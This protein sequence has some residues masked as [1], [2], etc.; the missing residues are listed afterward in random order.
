MKMGKNNKDIE[1]IKK[2]IEKINFEI[3][4][5]KKSISIKKNSDTQ[6]FKF[7]LFKG[8]EGFADRLQC[9]LQAIKY[10]LATNRILIIDWRDED[11]SHDINQPIDTYFELKGVKNM[12]IKDFLEIWDKEKNSL[13][14]YPIAWKDFI[15]N[16][17][18][19]SLLE[20]PIFHLPNQAKC[21]ED[22]SINKI[23]DFDEDIIVYP[24][25]QHRTFDMQYLQC[26]DLSDF[27]KK[28]ILTFSRKYSLIS[29]KYDVIHL[30]GGSKKWM[31]GKLPHNSLVKES[32]NKWNNANE[33]MDFLYEKYISESKKREDLPLLL[34]SDTH[35]LISLW[36][37]KYKIGKRVPN[38]VA[39][40]LN[41][42]G[43]HKLKK[44][45]IIKT[46]NI[47]KIEINF[48]CI[49]DFI[50]MLNSRILI[51]DEVSLYSNMALLA[52]SINIRLIDFI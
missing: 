7:I 50:L 17:N 21:I 28:K 51:G 52:K 38:I 9:L 24:G 4:T 45:D 5:I 14:I 16:P 27:V 40:K 26:I 39:D 44:K 10:A 12:Y 35:Q 23:K 33:Y 48:E 25:I 37:E 6:N 32:H 11:W 46:K 34:I 30:R 41:E 3:S 49:R 20:N 19:D 8:K 43:I 29:K 31:G 47:S 13:T 22:I 42:S 2:N 18:C 15:E 36:E 1:I